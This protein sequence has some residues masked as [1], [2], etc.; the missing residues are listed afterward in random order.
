MDYLRS[1]KS[2]SEQLINSTFSLNHKPDPFFVAIHFST[3]KQNKKEKRK[4]PLPFLQSSLWR[5]D[6]LEKKGERCERKKAYK[7]LRDQYIP[8]L[9]KSSTFDDTFNPPRGSSPSFSTLVCS[10]LHGM[11][12]PL[13]PA[14]A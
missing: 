7:E 9:I 8:Y 4:N 3:K 14:R 1:V 2:V 11:L 5:G 10:D 13:H 12:L 6:V